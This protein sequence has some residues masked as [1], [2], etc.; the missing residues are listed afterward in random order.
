MLSPSTVT[1][2]TSGLSRAPLQT[3]HG[4]SRRYSATR[5]ALPVGL[6]LEVLALDVRDDALEARRVLH[7]AAVAVLPLDRDLEV[8]APQHRLL[9]VIAQFAPRGV[10][11][12]VQV[13][14][15]AVEKLLEVVEEPL[16]G[17]RPRQDRAVGDADRVVGDE[18]VGVHRHARP[19]SRALGAGAERCVERERARLDLGELDGVAVRAGQLLGE[20]AP[21]GI[22]GLV[23]DVDRDEAV[24]QA[25]RRLERVGEARE[26]VLAGD[27]SVDDDRDVVLELLLEDRRV[28]ELDLLAIDDRA[29]V[30]A[31]GEILEQVD[32]LALLLRDHR[33]H[34][35]VARARLERHELV[36]DLLHGLLLDA[37]TAFGAVRYSDARPQQSH[38][39]VDLGD[40]A[41]RGPRVAVGGLLVD[42]D[43]RT[44]SFDEVHVGPVD[45]A[46]ELPG[47]G[48]ERLDVAAL[49]L[50]ED[51]VEGE[52]RLAGPRQPGE[53]DER[54]ARDVQVDVAQVVHARASNAQHARGAG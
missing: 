17:A 29:R 34:D 20:G 41:D 21:R 15:E 32:E 48:G 26:D 44:Q 1:A 36:G 50:G 23:D 4:I 28:A 46:E 2:S 18:Q 54:V 52:A 10:E 3:G 47:V 49:A 5:C 25:Q 7:L 40:R 45:L 8:V 39:V 31:R 14:R 38:V 11:R 37:L 6:R 35:L 13:A 22:P 30:A 24:G 33:A 16:P 27:E 12:E 9:D 42:G 19:E 51:G 43:R 53:H